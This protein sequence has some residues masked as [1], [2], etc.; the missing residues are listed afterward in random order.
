MKL[1][2][3]NRLFF[4]TARVLTGCLLAAGQGCS[5]QASPGCTRDQVLNATYFIEKHAVRLVNGRAEAPAAPGAAAGSTTVLVGEP[6]LGDVDGNGHDDAALFL[7]RQSGGSGTFYY[8]AA[9]LS[10]QSTCQGTNAVFLGD[11]ISPKQIHIDKGMIIADFVDRR[12]DQPMT[13]PPA[14][15][16]RLSFIL[17]E[18][19]L[20]AMESSR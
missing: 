11:R 4:N 5:V 17:K 2:K 6:V 14:I 3:K 13:E 12:P 10:K 8:L 20:E 18:G 1:C 16:R 9:A 15:N 19:S 7:V